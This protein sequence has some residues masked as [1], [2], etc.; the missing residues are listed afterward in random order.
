MQQTDRPKPDAFS[1]FSFMFQRLRNFFQRV[2]DGLIG[3]I[4][5]QRQVRQL[6]GTRQQAFSFTLGVGLLAIGLSGWIIWSS[7]HRLGQQAPVNLLA[8]ANT[9]TS[10]EQLS[11]LEN[12]DTDGDGL[13]DYTELFQLKTSPYL[14]DSDSDGIDDATEVRQGTDPNCPAGKSCTGFTAGVI[15]NSSDQLTPDFLRQALRDAGVAQSVLDNIPDDQL[16]GIYQ[17]VLAQGGNVNAADLTL[18]DL[19]QLSGDEIRQLLIQSGVGASDIASYDD[20]TLK[21]IFLQGLNQ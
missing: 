16:L 13:S 3:I 5:G 17:E 18:T 19:Q 9:N 2:I 21:Q 20:A 10:V 7:I 8:N 14:K 1:T 12:K 4:S 6:D 11:A 15:V